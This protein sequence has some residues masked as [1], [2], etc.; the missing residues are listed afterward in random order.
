M[1]N[2]LVEYQQL[3]TRQIYQQRLPHAIIIAGHTGVGKQ[4]L[5]EWLT[6][7]LACQHK[8]EKNDIYQACNACKSCQLFQAKTHPD[9]FSLTTDTNTLGVDEI[10]RFITFFQ[11]KAQLSNVQTATIEFADKMTV[12]A[13]NALLKTLEEPPANSYIFLTTNELDIFLPTIVSR[14]T[15]ITIRPPVGSKLFNTLGLQFEDPFANISQLAELTDSAQQQELQ[16]FVHNLSRFIDQGIEHQQLVKQMLDNDHCLRWLEKFAVNLMRYRQKW[17][18]QLVSLP[19]QTQQQMLF[20][21]DQ[22]S[23]T[24]IY[25]LIIAASRQVKTLVQANR[26]FVFEKL[27]FDIADTVK[28]SLQT[29]ATLR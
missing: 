12:S 16:Q 1:R 26:Q 10:R 7:V 29:S 4:L 25:R 21:L 14:C 2:W 13:A 27:L 18:V 11:T 22:Q 23:L 19:E 5:V 15:V 24:V 20:S 17:P 9:H 3:L 28:A 8:T 6:Q